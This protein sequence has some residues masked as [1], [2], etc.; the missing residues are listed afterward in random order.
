MISY[1][2]KV[3]KVDKPAKAME[4][5][6]SAPGK[7][8]VLVGA[9]LPYLGESLD[10]IV[11]MYAPTR[12]WEEK[13]LE[14]E[15]IVEGIYG[16]VL[17]PTYTKTAEDKKRELTEAIQLRLDAF[18]STRGYDGILS[19]CTYAT[20]TNTKFAVEGQRAV[21]L[22]DATWAAAYGV[23]DRVTSGETPEP[24]SF[25]EIAQYLPELTWTN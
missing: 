16:T 25:E 2:F 21:E 3:L 20:S 24:D 7:E 18:A 17:P 5:E 12:Y 10:S 22:R 23:F 19:A 9:R 8:T 14:V 11:A 1:S 15:D 6:Y 4:I 13:E